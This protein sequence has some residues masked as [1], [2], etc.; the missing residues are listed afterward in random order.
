MT[1]DVYADNLLIDCGFNIYKESE[2]A[3]F[4]GKIAEVIKTEYT[5]KL[6][7]SHVSV[8]QLY[9]YKAYVKNIIDGDTLWVNIDC[10]FKIWVKQK[11]RL[12][13][14]D[15]P[16]IT[17]PKGAQAYKFVCKELKGLPF[18][19]IKSHG[20]GKYGRYLVDIFYLK[21]E[22]NPLVVLNKGMFLNQRLLDEGL[23]EREY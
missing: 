14:V 22:E 7:V 20:R 11:I 15:A 4:K 5:Y 18:I 16:G 2:T 8:R 3:K 12:R 1:K 13:G 10:G 6:I 21:G 9:T 19:I 17:S 23:G